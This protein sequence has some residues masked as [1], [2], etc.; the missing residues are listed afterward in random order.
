MQE[1][2]WECTWEHLHCRFVHSRD[3]WYPWGGVGN[4]TGWYERWDQRGRQL[5]MV[6]FTLRALDVIR[7]REAWRGRRRSSS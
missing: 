4:E 2:A 5:V 7:R 3:G 6:L 1:S